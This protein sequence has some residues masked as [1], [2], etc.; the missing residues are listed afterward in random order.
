MKKS[1]IIF[2]AFY[3]QVIIINFKT[4]YIQCKTLNINTLKVNNKNNQ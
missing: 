4:Q 2:I 1:W 3:F